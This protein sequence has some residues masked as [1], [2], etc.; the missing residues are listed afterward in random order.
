MEISELLGG[1]RIVPVVSIADARLAVPLAEIL[2]SSGISIIEITLRT[3]AAL[4][5]IENISRAVPDM[6]VGAGSIRLAEQLVQIRDA[7]ARFA[8]S[9]GA[10]DKLINQAAQISMPFI[11]GAL[12]PS[13]MLVLLERGFTLQKFFPAETS[14]GIDL[15]RAVATPIPEVR[16]MATGGISA[17]LAIDYLAEPNVAAIGGSWIAP[18]S[19]IKAGDFDQIARMASQAAQHNC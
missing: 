2:L 8:V 17:A 5:A 13:E 16:F 19:L 9:P 6:K 10:T 3:P 18:N 1:T 12:T 7:G 4:E 11:P 14:G 15:L